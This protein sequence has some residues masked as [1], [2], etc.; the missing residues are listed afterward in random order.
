MQKSIRF[1][2]ENLSGLYPQRETESFIKLIFSQL[3]GYSV[4]DFILHKDNILSDDMRRQIEDI[5]EKLIQKV[6][7]QYALGYTDFYGYNFQVSPDVLI[8]RPE[9]EEL[10]SWIIEENPQFEG[11]LADLGTGSGCIAIS[12]ALA[13]PLAYTEGW[14]IS[15]AA[16]QIAAANGTRLKAGT[17]WIKNDILNFIPRENDLRFDIIVSNPPY[18]CEQEKQDMDANVLEYEP[19]TALFVPDDDPLLFYRKIAEISRSLLH[20]EGELFFEINERF[21]K[22][23][24]EL[25]ADMNFH[26]IRI[27]HDIFGKERMIAARYNQ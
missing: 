25:L 8:P 26:D 21:G 13:F 11:N 27:K 19:H 16:L 7:I 2:R 6:P 10:V 23:C 3:C 20:H 24:Q 17:K 5:T 22:E 15:D 9:T 4:T 18:V 12:L 1:I 14:D